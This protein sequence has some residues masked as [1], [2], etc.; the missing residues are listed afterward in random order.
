MATNSVNLNIVGVHGDTEVVAWS[1]ATIDGVSIDQPSRLSIADRNEL[2]VE[3]K[4]RTQGVLN[5]KGKTPLGIGSVILSI[6]SSI[7]ADKRDINPI[8]HFHPEWGCCFS[9][10]AMLGREGI[11]NTIPTPLNRDERVSFVESVAA[12]KA[13]IDRVDEVRCG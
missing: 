12:L 9:L 13:T 7:F 10:P 3:C 2:S 4:R 8:S 11:L 1:D 5:M 6:C